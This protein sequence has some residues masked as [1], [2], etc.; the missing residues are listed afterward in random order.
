MYYLVG[1]IGNTSTRI[2]LL[3]K[4]FKIVKSIIFDTKNIFTRGYI[5]KILKKTLKRNIKKKILFSC[6]VPKAYRKI[7]KDFN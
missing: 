1:D 6:V 2:C 4:K 7:R 5:K 3:N